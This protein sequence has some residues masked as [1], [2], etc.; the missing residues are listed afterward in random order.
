MTARLVLFATAALCL[1]CGGGGMT[2]EQELDKMC[3]IAG[4]VANDGNLARADKIKAFEDKVVEAGLPTMMKA[5]IRGTATM[6]DLD[7]QVEVMTVNMPKTLYEI[8]GWKCD[9]VRDLYQVAS[10]D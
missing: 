5:T 6:D 3:E 10:G 1:A 2:P 7:R 9:N 4:E 8:E